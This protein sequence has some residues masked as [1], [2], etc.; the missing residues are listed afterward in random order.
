MQTFHILF[1]QTKD[2]TY[3]SGINIEAK[4]P[5]HAIAIFNYHHKQEENVF[6]SCSNISVIPKCN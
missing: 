3:C 6:I 2:S 1:F 4:D 5:M